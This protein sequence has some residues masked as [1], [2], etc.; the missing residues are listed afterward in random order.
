MILIIAVFLKNLSLENLRKSFTENVFFVC[1]FSIVI[2]FFNSF[3]SLKIC[4]NK[5]FKNKSIPWSLVI[6][7]V[8]VVQSFVRWILPWL[9]TLKFGPSLPLMRNG[10][11]FGGLNIK[12]QNPCT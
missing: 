10:Y 9:K 12:M 11:P 6:S 3:V 8:R 7:I 5:K 4:P 1:L 2:S